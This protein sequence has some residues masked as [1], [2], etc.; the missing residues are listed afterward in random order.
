ML[1][2]VNVTCRVLYS[3]VGYL[4]VSCSGSITSIGKRELIRLLSLTCN[5]VVSVRRGFP[6]LL[7]LGKGCVILLWLSLGLPYNYSGR[8]GIVLS[9]VTTK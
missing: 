7:V 9:T 2:R 4:Y 1:F 8:R 5:Y 3:F 6:F